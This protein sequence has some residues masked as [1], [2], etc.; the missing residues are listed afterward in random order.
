M[1]KNTSSRILRIVSFEE[2]SSLINA[3]YNKPVLD[4]AQVKEAYRCEY[5]EADS[6]VRSKLTMLGEIDSFGE[7]D[8]SMGNPWNS[9]RKIGIT[10]NT[11]HHF[12]AEVIWFLQSAIQTIAVE[13]LIILSG[14][15]ELGKGTFYIC[16]RKTGDI[17]GYA[18][19]EKTLELFGFRQSKDIQS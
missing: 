5:E 19:D 15:I 11:V 7:K 10:I 4:T 13:Y 6:L 9:S 17:I 8:F 3:P 16:I 14:E 18:P 1:S 12:N 2:A